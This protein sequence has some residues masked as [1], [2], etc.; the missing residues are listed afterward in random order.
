MDICAVTETWFKPGTGDLTVNKF[1]W[2][3]RDR[4]NQEK[5]RRGHGGVGL[6][7]KLTC[8]MVKLVK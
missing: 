6:I 5:A 7:V 3:G 4:L 2:F 8:G 1:C